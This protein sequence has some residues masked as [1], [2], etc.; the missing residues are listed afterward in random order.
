MTEKEVWHTVKDSAKAIGVAKLAPHDLRRTCVTSVAGHAATLRVG[1][2]KTSCP[3]AQFTPI[4]AAM[5]A[6]EPGDVIEICPAL[7][8]EQLVI[9]KPWLCGESRLT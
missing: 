9:T 4:T 6:A 2:P 1:Q 7:Y 5:N 8:S 3:H